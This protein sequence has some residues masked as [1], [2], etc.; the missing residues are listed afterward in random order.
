MIPG[1][2]GLL[3]RPLGA[4]AALTVLA[5]PAAALCAP[6]DPAVRSYPAAFFA[7]ARPQTA[8]DMVQRLPGFTFTES[9]Q[10]RGLASSAGNVLID[11]E[12]PANKQ[13]FLSDILARIPASTVAR[14][15]V[16]RGASSSLDMQGL[17][18]VANVVRLDGTTRTAAVTV[19]DTVLTDDG[20]HM[21]QVKLEGA[22]RSAARSIEGSLTVER[23]EDETVGPGPHR[24]WDASGA[25]TYDA[26]LSAQA[27]QWMET[28]TGA[29]EQPLAGGRLRITGLASNA[30]YADREADAAIFPAGAGDRYIYDQTQDRGEIGVHYDR[31]FGGRARLETIVLQQVERVI[32]PS[33]FIAPGDDERLSADTLLAES[34]ARAT[35][36]YNQ[37][38]S[39]TIEAAAEGAYNSQDVHSRYAVNGVEQAL[40]AADSHVREL[41]GE[42]SLA[43]TW[44]PTRVY[45][46]EA[47]LR[48]EGSTISAVGS[49]TFVYPKP[50]AVFTWSPDRTDQIRVRIERQVSQLDFSDFAVTGALNAG[51]VLAGNPTLRPEDD[52][53]YEASYERG[54]WSG[55]DVTI[56]YRRR[57]MNNA[58][59]WV[60]VRAQDGTSYAEPGN[61]GR[62]HVNAVVLDLTLPLDR[63][64][65]K[66]GL[67]KTSDTWR[68]STVT[69][70]TTGQARALSDIGA[71]V[72]ELKFTQDLP[73]WKSTWGV[74][75]TGPQRDIRYVFNQVVAYKTDAQV[76]VFYDYKPTPRYDVRLEADN[77]SGHR[78]TTVIKDFDQPR[79]AGASADLLDVRAQRISPRVMLSVRYSLE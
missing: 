9:N 72:G 27:A 4:L 56:T 17:T 37:S 30:T 58:I 44:S 76:S 31:D 18:V 79:T 7:A 74:T 35:L 40:P 28:A 20:R 61:I 45:T 68:L 39:L 11:G 65:I 19:A 54:F 70:P 49:K 41:R 53:I 36:R 21:P 10:A 14:I 62:G 50:H 23:D 69:D 16:V 6:A 13:D 33:H 32:Q 67:I 73:R 26:R 57:E 46:L 1:R 59:D 3:F 8:L 42:A 24:Q 43:A 5:A 66:G 52:W 15:D 48:L 55:G 77:A 22:M 47:G 51:G 34:T 2:L 71:F 60:D 38:R 75:W 29:Y 63:L 64:G 25:R 78:Y 12:R